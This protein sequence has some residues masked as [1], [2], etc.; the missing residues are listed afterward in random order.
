MA[1]PSSWTPPP[2]LH[3][4][5]NVSGMLGFGS[6][7]YGVWFVQPEWKDLYAIVIICKDSLD[8]MHLVWAL[9]TISNNQPHSSYNTVLLWISM[10]PKC[11]YCWHS[12]AR[13]EYKWWN[14][15]KLQA[16]VVASTRRTYQTSVTLSSLLKP[17][18]WTN[19]AS[20]EHFSVP[21]SW[22]GQ[23]WW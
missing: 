3:F 5:T 12:S 21:A 6:N 16:V 7:W 22:L 2:E 19:I 17:S 15:T 20:H 18:L 1:D 8:L 4:Y 10:P 11:H 14:Y 9:H 23:L 13:R